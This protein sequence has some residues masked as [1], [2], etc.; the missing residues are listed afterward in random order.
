VIEGNEKH[1]SE[2]KGAFTIDGKMIDLPVVKWAY[3]V[4]AMQNR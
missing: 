4:L 3:N 2:G 1:Q